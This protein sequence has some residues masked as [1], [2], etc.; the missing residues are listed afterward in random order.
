M[1]FGLDQWFPAA[2]GWNRQDEAGWG[3]GWEQGG[4]CP[5]W[6]GRAGFRTDSSDGYR[7][8]GWGF[9]PHTLGTDPES[10]ASSEE[11]NKPIFPF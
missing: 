9:I 5:S 3:R 7:A 8:P 11:I 2:A 6:M 4:D 10:S 1:D